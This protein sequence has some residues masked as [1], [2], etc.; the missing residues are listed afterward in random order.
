MKIGDYVAKNKGF[1]SEMINP[2]GR[3]GLVVGVFSYS[4]RNQSYRTRKLEVLTAE[5]IL[6]L[7]ID[8]FCEVLYESR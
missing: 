4:K 7:W 2:A 6:E 8:K 1:G 3:T 5:G